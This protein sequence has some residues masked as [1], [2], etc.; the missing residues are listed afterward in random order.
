MA[1]RLRI[2][3]VD[4]HEDTLLALEAALIPLG[5]P[6]ER[7]TGGAQALKAALK[8]CVGLIVMDVRMPRVSGLEVARYLVR[9]DQTRHIPII[10][11][12]GMWLDDA[13]T[14]EALE[15]GVADIIHKPI[16][17]NALQVKAGYLMRQSEEFAGAP[18]SDRRR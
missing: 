9:L 17:V 1:D 6:V 7:A 4:D 15:A 10:L 13:L 12:T 14:G 5:H 8:G 18:T 16:N 3:L 11:V 2:L